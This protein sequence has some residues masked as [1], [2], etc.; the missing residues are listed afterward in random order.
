MLT[1]TASSHASTLSTTGVCHASCQKQAG[2]HA[3]VLSL[4]HRL[5]LTS[6]V[7]AGL[8]EGAHHAVVLLLLKDGEVSELG[9][10]GLLPCPMPCLSA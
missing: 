10:A 2:Q 9:L 3:A 6:A 5:I 8:V 7:C 1:L 4:S